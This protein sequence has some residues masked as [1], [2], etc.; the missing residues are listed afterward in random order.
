MLSPLVGRGNRVLWGVPL[1]GADRVSARLSVSRGDVQEA[2]SSPCIVA[3]HALGFCAPVSHRAARYAPFSGA[4]VFF[5]ADQSSPNLSSIHRPL[6]PI[7]SHPPL[8]LPYCQPPPGQAVLQDVHR[9]QGPGQGCRQ[10]TRKDF[11]GGGGWRRSHGVT[12]TAR[13]RRFG[14]ITPAP[15]P[16]PLDH[17]SSGY[18]CFC[19]LPRAGQ[20][21]VGRKPPTKNSDDW[22]ARKRLQNESKRG[23]ERN[24]QGNGFWRD[25]A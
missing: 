19:F 11:M 9:H 14:G 15:L 20:V 2:R 1:P 23:V 4:F 24:D 16:L 21:I 13:K 7:L 3:K 25:D 8:N 10:G 6:T 17:S 12:R 18:F 5:F 22:V